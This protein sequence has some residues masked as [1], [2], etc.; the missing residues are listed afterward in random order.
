MTNTHITIGGHKVS[1]GKVYSTSEVKTGDVWIDGKPI[2]RKVITPATP[3]TADGTEITDISAVS[4]AEIVN[5]Y[6]HIVA[7]DYTRVGL[8][9][10]I[11]SNQ[12]VIT[13]FTG[14]ATSVTGIFIRTNWTRILSTTG[15]ITLEYT[16]TTD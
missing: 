7:N 6:G 9:A 14:T 5:F 8:N 2:Y 12:Y 10:F 3:S 11:G 4:I 1:A 16:K 13:G 15:T